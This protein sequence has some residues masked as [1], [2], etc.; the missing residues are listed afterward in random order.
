MTTA[1][2]S[3]PI[4]RFS[5]A[6][7]SPLDGR[8]AA[9]RDSFPQI[10]DEDELDGDRLALELGLREPRTQQR[11]GLS[12]PGKEQAILAVQETSIGTLIPDRDSSISFDDSKDAVIEGDNLEV[13]KL[14]QRAYYGKVKMIF[15]DPPYNTG[16]NFIYPDNFKEG[17]E[18]YLRF[19]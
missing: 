2:P 11:Y 17:L 18:S 12:W 16:N 6:S 15:I 7:L 1:V 19:T 9:I 4:E 10:L 3:D 14:L 13:L 8:Y 5:L